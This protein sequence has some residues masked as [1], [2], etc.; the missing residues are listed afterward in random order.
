MQ[1]YGYQ[2]MPDG[3]L[4]VSHHGESFYGPWPVRF[5]VSLHAMYVIWATDKHINSPLFGNQTEEGLEAQEHQRSNIPLYVAKGWIDSLTAQQE[6]AIQ[7]G[8]LKRHNTA[9][10]EANLATLKKMA[11]GD[12]TMGLNRKRDG[13]VKV[14]VKDPNVQAAIKAALQDVKKHEGADAAASA[15]DALLAD[16]RLANTGKAKVAA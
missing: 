8:K 16:Q 2:R 7:T 4:E 12:V 9:D 5:I 3:S 13:S 15:L 6:K 10:A 14:N 11:E 1:N